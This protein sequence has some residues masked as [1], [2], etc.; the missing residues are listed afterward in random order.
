[1]QRRDLLVVGGG[2][3][4]L[5]AARTAARLGARVVLVERARTGGDCLWTGCVPSKAFLAAAAHAH[6]ARAGARFGV[7]AAEPDVD[8]AAVMAHVHAARER[9]AP[10]DSVEA[11]AADGVEVRTG[12]LRFTGPG[13]A[14]VDGT[15][16]RFRRAVVA[17]GADPVV[18]AIPGLADAAPLTTDSVWDVDTPVRSLVVLGAGPIGC[19]LGQ[20]F[21]RLGTAV[22]L[23]EA[24]DRVLPIEEPAAS[25]RLRAALVRDGVDVRTGARAL[26]VHPGRDGPEVELDRGARVT[27]ERILVA[28]GRAPATAEL[29]LEALGVACA[30]SGHVVVDDRLRTSA[31]GVFAAGDVVGDLPSGGAMPFTHV[32][33]VHGSVAATNAVLAPL[34]RVDHRGM[35]RVTYT[36]PEVANVGLTEDQARA[37]HDGVRVRTLEHGEVDRA[38]TED[39]TGGVTRVVLD[40]RARVLGATVV[41]PR[42]AEVLGELTALAARR[43]RLRDL[44]GITH[45][46]PGWGDAVWNAALAELADALTTPAARRAARL[47]VRARRVVPLGRARAA[48]PAARRR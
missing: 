3:A 30:P 13:R 43:G 5:V 1:V 31:P 16:L 7:R 44:A 4:G 40:R 11:L 27:G 38:V 26:A 14:E 41:G 35:P 32:A 24:A 45:P 12:I 23:V 28:L 36:D 15:P 21:A 34:R 10:V 8:L 18:P 20:G 39:E 2:T 47:G 33:G 19:E 46:Y 29:G 37:A 48:R 6:A 25:A 42:A 22:T 9:I 17:A